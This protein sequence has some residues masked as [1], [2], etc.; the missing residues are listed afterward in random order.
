MTGRPIPLNIFMVGG[1][2]II[3]V[4]SRQSPR[5]FTKMVFTKIKKCIEIPRR[6]C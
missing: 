1:D 4:I 5:F 6:M 2:E 3:G